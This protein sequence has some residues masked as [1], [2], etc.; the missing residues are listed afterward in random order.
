MFIGRERELK[1]LEN[2]YEMNGFG[3]TIIYGRR[4]VEKS[5]RVREFVKGK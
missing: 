5:T 2:I 3:M 4:R 1:S